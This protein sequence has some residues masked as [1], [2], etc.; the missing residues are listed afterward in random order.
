MAILRSVFGVLAGV[1]VGSGL[2]AVIEAFGRSVYPPPPGLDPRDAEALREHIASLPAGALLIVAVAHLI[3]PMVGAW[4]S[5]KIAGRRPMLHAIVT[6]AVFL[7][8][9][10]VNLFLVP[11][12]L[13]FTALDLLMYPLAAWL[14]GSL[15][16]IGFAGTA[17]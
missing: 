13:W 3:G 12:P 10:I 9:G 14:A 16:R 2:V 17:S 1:I 8:F 11:H 5:A 7:F 4:L 15:A 6:G